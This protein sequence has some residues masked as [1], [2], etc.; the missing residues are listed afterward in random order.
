MIRQRL[1][2]LHIYMHF[3][4]ILSFILRVLFNSRVYSLFLMSSEQ[5]Q[6]AVQAASDAYVAAHQRAFL[7]ETDVIH[8][9]DF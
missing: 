6:A 4:S 7:S 8:Q 2:E 1:P 3:L 5:D 9:C